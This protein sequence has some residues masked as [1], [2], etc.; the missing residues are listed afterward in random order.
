MASCLERVILG[1]GRQ[2]RWLGHSSQKAVRNQPHLSPAGGTPA[3]AMLHKEVARSHA[4]ILRL[5]RLRT[6]LKVL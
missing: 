5:L 4:I 6:S 2:A 3:V 1:Y